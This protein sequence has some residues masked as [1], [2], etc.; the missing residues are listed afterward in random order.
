MSNK[1]KSF[2]F[3]GLLG[4]IEEE[5][6]Q[7]SR[8]RQNQKKLGK[9]IRVTLIIDEAYVDKIKSVSFMERKLIKEVWNEA[10]NSYLQSYEQKN[11]EIP[12]PKK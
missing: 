12:I 1:K 8:E 4:G 3:D 7:G 5:H 11:G 10:I 2:G 6:S 9:E